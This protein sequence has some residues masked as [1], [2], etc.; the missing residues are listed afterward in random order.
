MLENCLEKFIRYDAEGKAAEDAATKSYT[1]MKNENEVNR[2]MKTTATKNKEQEVTRVTNLVGD[3]KADR[4]GS[5]SELDAVLDY[6]A[7]LKKKCEH[8]PMSFEERAARRK[9]EIASLQ[10][11]LDILENETAT[12]FLQTVRLH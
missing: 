10:E 7:K 5:Q 9:Q 2:A 4:A 11:A 6:L 8:T 12:A 3:L 1:K